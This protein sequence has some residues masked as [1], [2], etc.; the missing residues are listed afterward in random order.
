MPAAGPGLLHLV[1]HGTGTLRPV[2]I[3]KVS[4][5]ILSRTRFVDGNPCNRCSGTSVET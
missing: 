4:C 2:N 3:E 1:V 5:M